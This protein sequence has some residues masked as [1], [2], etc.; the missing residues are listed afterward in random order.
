MLNYSLDE[1]TLKTP[2]KTLRYEDM[3]SRSRELSINLIKD[4][5]LTTSFVLTYRAGSQIE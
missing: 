3:E 1:P 4:F 5:F 2:F